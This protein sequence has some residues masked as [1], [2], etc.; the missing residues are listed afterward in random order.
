MHVLVWAYLTEHMHIR[1]SGFCTC[2]Q[3]LTLK[4][5]PYVQLSYLAFDMS[6]ST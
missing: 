5:V 4:D 2:P 1:V 6:V 3:P